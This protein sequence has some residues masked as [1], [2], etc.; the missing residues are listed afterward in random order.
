[1]SLARVV[2]SDDLG[3]VLSCVFRL[4]ERESA[5]LSHP[6]RCTDLLNRF[7]EP[8]ACGQHLKQEIDRKSKLTAPV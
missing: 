8:V 7:L 2:R 4:T 5:V 6:L 1:M 3:L